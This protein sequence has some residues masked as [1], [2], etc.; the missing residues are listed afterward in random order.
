MKYYCPKNHKIWWMTN[1]GQ[2]S[3]YKDSDRVYYLLIFQR[4]KPGIR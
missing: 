3:C 4:T 1:M 2:L